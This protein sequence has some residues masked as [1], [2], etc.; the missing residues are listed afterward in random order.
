MT[1][2]PRI[3]AHR[4]LA[5]CT[6]NFRCAAPPCNR[7]TFERLSVLTRY[8]RNEVLHRSLP[9]SERAFGARASGVPRVLLYQPPQNLALA[10]FGHVRELNQT[11]V[12]LSFQL[13][14]LVQHVRHS[15]AHS[16]TKVTTG[17]PKHDDCTSG[18]VL[19]AVIANA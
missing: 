10:K 13:T 9:V 5:T 18:H 14:E 15:A 2:A 8:H 7:S 16:G 11:H 1:S 4:Q 19:A 12:T 6:R 3:V 17:A